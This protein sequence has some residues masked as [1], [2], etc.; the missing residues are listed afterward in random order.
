[1]RVRRSA[2]IA[3][4]SLILSLALLGA[5]LSRP[6]EVQGQSSY[7]WSGNELTLTLPVAVK[8]GIW[9]YCAQWGSSLPVFNEEVSLAHV[10]GSSLNNIGVYSEELLFPTYQDAIGIRDWPLESIQWGITSDVDR[11]Y[12][13]NSDPVISQAATPSETTFQGETY[14]RL[15]V[16]DGQ[17]RNRPMLPAIGSIL[18]LTFDS[19]ALTTGTP[20]TPESVSV[21]RSVDYTEATVSWTLHD[22]VA[23]YEIQ[24]EEA[25]TVSVGDISRIEYGNPETF[26][27]EATLAGVAAYTDSTVAPE[28]TYQYRVRAMGAEWGPWSSWV[29]VS[30]DPSRQKLDEPSNLQLDRARNNSQVT[31]S[32][33]APSDSVDNYTLQREELSEGVF[34]NAL[35]FSAAGSDWLPATATSYTDSAIL[36][37]RTYRY[38]AAGVRDDVVGEYSEWVTSAPTDIIFAP[39]PENLHVERDTRRDDRR[40]YWLVWDDVD[41][42]TDYELQ[43]NVTDP[44]T[45]ALRREMGVIVTAPTY[46][47]TA[48]GRREFRLRG[49]KQDAALCGSGADEYCY[50]QWTGW[51]SVGFIPTVSI[52]TPDALS[53]PVPQDQVSQEL[54][55]DMVAL[56]DFG[57]DA[58]GTDGDSDQLINVMVLV[59]ALGLGVGA[60]VVGFKTGMAPV[61]AGAGTCL[62]LAVLWIGVLTLDVPQQWGIIATL[63]ILVF[64]LAAGVASLRLARG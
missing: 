33:T 29:F 18:T 34:A 46:F 9:K 40:E 63:V 4:P 54:R 12:I 30:A 6:A 35:T 7:E 20:S 2:A 21:T 16:G 42:R 11:Y 8:E 62:A 37:G 59:M 14:Y 28:K 49:R 44:G 60:F 64:G 48:Y 53:T 47:A 5:A 57:F 26:T 3:V 24:R 41:G 61:G 51:H 22:P 55:E 10:C 43:I 27:V 36:P 38:R 17:N 31:I 25:T 50:T 58:L 15:A 52:E 1:M 45:G 19:A 23:K 13:D 39:P 56:F 32:W